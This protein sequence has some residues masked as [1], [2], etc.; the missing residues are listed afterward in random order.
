MSEA[1]DTNPWLKGVTLG[2]GINRTEIYLLFMGL[3]DKVLDPLFHG[4]E[5]SI[6]AIDGVWAGFASFISVIAIGIILVGFSFSD[7]FRYSTIM[8]VILTFLTSVLTFLNLKEKLKSKADYRNA[9]F[10]AGMT[11]VT[12]FVLTEI[13]FSIIGENKTVFIERPIF[14]LLIP[15]I[16]LLITIG[17]LLTW[18]SMQKNK[19]NS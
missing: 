5:S 13:I 4:G 1:T 18:D 2:K 17:G 3:L 7:L 14:V 16:T 15:I 8:L 19:T 10:V 6:R 9:F 11:S 12:L